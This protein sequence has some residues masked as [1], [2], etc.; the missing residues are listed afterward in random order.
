MTVPLLA[1]V[2]GLGAGAAGAGTL[3]LL[4]GAAFVNPFELLVAIASS[5]LLA[6]AFVLWVLAD[7]R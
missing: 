1:A 2:I 6:T 3:V 7:F 5:M 4:S